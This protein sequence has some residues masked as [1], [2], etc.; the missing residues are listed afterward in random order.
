[1][2]MVSFYF[3]IYE[4]LIRLWKNDILKCIF[5]SF[6]ECK[7]VFPDNDASSKCND[8]IDT[9]WF[10]KEGKDLC[11]KGKDSRF[12]DKNLNRTLAEACPHMC[13]QNPPICEGARLYF[14]QFFNSGKT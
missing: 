10:K 4:F 12:A 9:D 6:P 5:F 8:W 7:P 1:M 14:S 3:R 2:E 13:P 11:K